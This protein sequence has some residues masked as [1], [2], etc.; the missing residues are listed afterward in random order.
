MKTGKLDNKTY[1]YLTKTQSL[2]NQS[3]YEAID[4]ITAEIAKEINQAREFIDVT[5]ELL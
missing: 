1:K 5:K 2:R 3:D 4:D